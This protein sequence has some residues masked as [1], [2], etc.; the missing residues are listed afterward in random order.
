MCVFPEIYTIYFGNELAQMEHLS[1][2]YFMDPTTRVEVLNIR[3]AVQK[4][5]KTG[6]K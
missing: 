1:S 4:E 3:C 5:K 6:G 2:V